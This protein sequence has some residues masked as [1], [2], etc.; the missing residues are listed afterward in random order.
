LAWFLR[1]LAAA[2]H[3]AAHQIMPTREARMQ[4]SSRVHDRRAM[5]SSAL[6]PYVVYGF[7]SSLST[8]QTTTG[9]SVVSGAVDADGQWE[10]LHESHRKS[11]GHRC[12]PPPHASTSRFFLLARALTTTPAAKTVRGRCQNRPFTHRASEA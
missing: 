10:A 3:T 2:V 12:V 5:V 1:H 4:T 8:A 9:V 7:E 11:M 6:L